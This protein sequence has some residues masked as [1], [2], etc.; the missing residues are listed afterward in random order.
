M[1][2]CNS[3]NFQE[4]RSSHFIPGTKLRFEMSYYAKS[5]FYLFNGL[6]LSLGSGESVGLLL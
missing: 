3:K 5:A 2:Y 1:N 4:G 6:K